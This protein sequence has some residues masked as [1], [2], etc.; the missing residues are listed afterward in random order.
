MNPSIQNK[1]SGINKEYLD[2]LEFA[3]QQPG[4]A[5]YLSVY[6]E[7]QAIEKIVYPYNESIKIKQSVFASNSSDSF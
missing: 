5:E 6:N 2:I 3:L 4:V 7:W 1:E